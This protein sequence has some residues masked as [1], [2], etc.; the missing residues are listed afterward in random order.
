MQFSN[1]NSFY[2]TVVSNLCSDIYE[3]YTS[4]DFRNYFAKNISLNGEYKVAVVSIDYCDDFT[5]R[6]IPAH[7]N[8][9]DLTVPIIKPKT[10][11]PPSSTSTTEAT[12]D[13]GWL[14][15]EPDFFEEDNKITVQKLKKN[16]FVARKQ[17]NEHWANF[18]SALKT[19]LN[20]QPSIT[21][22]TNYDGKDEF[23]TVT[24]SIDDPENQNIFL[25]LPHEVS[26][27][28]GFQNKINL[29]AGENVAS[30][31]VSAEKY[32]N[33]AVSSFKIYF[34]SWVT[35]TF[36]LQKHVKGP[37]KIEFI[38]EVFH[39]IQEL[40]ISNG[41][42]ISMPVSPEGIL[43]VIFSEEEIGTYK[44]KLPRRLNRVL[45]L[46]DNYYFESDVE[47]V[48]TPSVPSITPT[49]ITVE[50]IEISKIEKNTVAN[51]LFILSDIVEGSIYGPY[52]RPILTSFLRDRGIRIPHRVEF[53]SL[54]FQKVICSHLKEIRIILTN[55]K[56][57][58]ITPSLYPTTVTL[59]F[60]QTK[61]YF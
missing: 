19:K 34:G 54:H 37:E 32:N 36:E 22:K 23:P 26:E 5:L 15:D 9:P 43:S 25:T 24:I 40:L 27:F 3:D 12:L 16:E 13:K 59:L 2:I 38:E 6:R 39:S 53:S 18:L 50:T 4:S 47:I 48:L 60:V 41:F 61:P 56:F 14:G 7:P 45:N 42:E 49:P 51:T 29:Y 31:K 30:E 21:M 11:R 55:S 58:P 33:I 10:T 28:L 52:V 57:S 17:L 8:Y 1:S 20:A 44:F 46:T 35:R